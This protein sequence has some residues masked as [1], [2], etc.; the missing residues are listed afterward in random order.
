MPVFAKNLGSLELIITDYYLITKT[1][2]KSPSKNAQTLPK[3]HV[4]MTRLEL[5]TSRPPGAY[6]T[7]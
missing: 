7:N 5:A 1:K 6:S 2:K 4:G 3:S